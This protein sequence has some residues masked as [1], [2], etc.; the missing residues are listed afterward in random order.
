MPGR[1]D[2][3]HDGGQYREHD[4]DDDPRQQRRLL[5]PRVIHD[6]QRD[7]RRRRDG[8]GPVRPYIQADGQCHRG[9]RCGL[10][11]DE[12]PAC[13]VA[14]ELAEP[15]PA[16]DVRAAGLGVT[17]RQ[18]G[19]RCGV[20]VRDDRRHGQADEQTRAGCRCGRGQ[21]R[22][23]SCTDH[24]PQ[25]D[26]DGVDSAEPALQAPGRG[27]A[28]DRRSVR[29]ACRDERFVGRRRRGPDQ[30]GHQCKCPDHHDGNGPQPAHQDG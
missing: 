18:P 19:R 2:D 25:A 29:V 23:D 28:R 26:D 13:G 21:G 7:H 14:P 27:H 15:F 8:M 11:D 17:G 16:V 12:A 1:D 22:E 6:R 4:R 9:A 20:A 30:H 24:R 10:A 5:D 3:D